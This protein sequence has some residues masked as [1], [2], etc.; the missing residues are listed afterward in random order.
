MNADSRDDRRKDPR[1]LTLKTGLISVGSAQGE[2]IVC[3]VLDESPDGAC[4]LVPQN[5]AIPDSFLVVLDGSNV[6]LSC[7]LKWRNGCRIGCE[8]KPPAEHDASGAA[9]TRMSATSFTPSSF[10][11]GGRSRVWRGESET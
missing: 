11:G 6:R 3:A 8:T 7:A 2:G 9:G 5:A 10:A 4:L 1:M